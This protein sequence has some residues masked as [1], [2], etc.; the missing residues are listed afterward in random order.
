MVDAGGGLEA[1]G[2]VAAKRG[3]VGGDDDGNIGVERLTN[4]PMQ[5]D[6]QREDQA[7]IHQSQYSREGAIDQGPVD[8]VVDLPQARAEHGKAKGERNKEGGT[9]AQWGEQQVSE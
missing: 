9:V 5:E 6:L 8:D 3:G 7:N 1:A 2:G 4:Q